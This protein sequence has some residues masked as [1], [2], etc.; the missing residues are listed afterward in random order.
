MY[1]D[2]K[3]KNLG[4][5]KKVDVRDIWKNE[6]LNFTPWLAENIDVISDKLGLDL[7]VEKTEV[8]AG[9]FSADILAK[10]TVTDT[11]V[12]IE[13]QL[14]KTD[15]DHLGK[16]ITYAS[17][18]DASTIIWI[19]SDFTEEHKK[20]ID[21]LNDLTNKDISFYGLKLEV[22]QIDN[23]PKAVNFDIISEPNETVRRTRTTVTEMTGLQKSQLEFWDDFKELL[24]S[25]DKSISLR[26]SQP[27]NWFDISIGKTD[28]HVSNSHSFQKN[29][30]TTGIYMRKSIAS[31]M[32]P[33]FES[34]KEDIEKKMGVELIWDP[35]PETSDKRILLRYSADLEDSQEREKA[36]EWM[37]KYAIKFIEVFSP[38]VKRYNGFIANSNENN[39]ISD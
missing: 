12:I 6:A 7:E 8:R 14:E 38:I 34:Q 21:W 33:F 29:E 13:N 10:D 26:K 31:E 1:S 2:N 17:I 11:Y 32:L 23:S 24:S 28:I 30:V 9:S 16:S 22:L 36:L 3:I 35:N 18:L 4:T 39:E 20:A 5:L 19:A 27:H 37:C 15:H 25:K